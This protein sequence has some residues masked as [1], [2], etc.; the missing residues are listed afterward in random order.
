MANGFILHH[1]SRFYKTLFCFFE[2]FFPVNNR[3]ECI[4]PHKAGLNGT[5]RFQR[6]RLGFT[7]GNSLKGNTQSVENGAQ[8]KRVPPGTNVPGGGVRG[9]F[10]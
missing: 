8:E 3:A 1:C 6:I 5:A 7:A 9:Y 10:I 4:R 2:R